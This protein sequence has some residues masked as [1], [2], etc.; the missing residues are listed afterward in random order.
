MCSRYEGFGLVLIEAMNCGLPCIS[1]NCPYGPSEII[2]N[3]IDGYLIDES[4][5]KQFINKLKSLMNDVNLRERMGT[6]AKNN[7]IRY[8]QSNIMNQW[9]DLLEKL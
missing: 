5:E 3:D 6:A 4:D 9:I 8:S 7:V 1:Y 2:N